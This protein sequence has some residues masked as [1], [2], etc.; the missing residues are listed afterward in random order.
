MGLGPVR[1]KLTDVLEK[2]GRGF[3]QANK[4]RQDVVVHGH[5]LSLQVLSFCIPLG[6]PFRYP[7]VEH[8]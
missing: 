4:T 8:F 3:L 6:G 2:A 5:K 7:H 1:E